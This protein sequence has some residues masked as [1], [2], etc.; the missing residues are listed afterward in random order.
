MINLCL[1][2]KPLVSF[3]E[4]LVARIYFFVLFN[5]GVRE[6]E[7]RE[8]EIGRFNSY[9]SVMDEVGQLTLRNFISLVFLFMTRI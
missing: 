9:S 2:C 5:M 1:S 4:F 3:I 7:E 8:R 6:R